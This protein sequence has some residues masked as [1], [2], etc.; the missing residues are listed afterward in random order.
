MVLQAYEGQ[1]VP[2]N[3]WDIASLTSSRLS[4]CLAACAGLSLSPTALLPAWWELQSNGNHLYLHSILF[5]TDTAMT[6]TIGFIAFVFAGG[7]TV[8]ARMGF[9]AAVTGQIRGQVAAVPAVGGTYFSRQLPAGFSG[10]LL[11][12]GWIAFGSGNVIL[13]STPVLA[14]NCTATFMWAEMA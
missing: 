7:W 11:A 2:E 5:D 1:G 6:V 3:L 10:N 14:A 4:A 9:G 8:G 12:P 13:L